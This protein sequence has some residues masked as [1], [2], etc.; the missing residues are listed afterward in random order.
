VYCILTRPCSFYA[1]EL[2]D[3]LYSLIP[4]ANILIAIDLAQTES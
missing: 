2:K 1:R 3:C 4:T